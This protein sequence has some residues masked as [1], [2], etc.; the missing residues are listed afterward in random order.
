MIIILILSRGIRFAARGYAGAGLAIACCRL[1][2]GDRVS[3]VERL[4]NVSTPSALMAD[5]GALT[6]S[7]R[8][9]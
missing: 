5:A 7:L 4:E 3:L 2:A 1:A 9:H 8:C 6:Q